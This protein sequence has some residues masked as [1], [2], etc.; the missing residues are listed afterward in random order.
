MAVAYQAIGT[1]AW[2]TGG[3]FS[4][5]WPTHQAGDIGIMILQTDTGMST[6]V[7]GWTDLVDNDNSANCKIRMLWKRASSSS[8][9]SEFV[10]HPGA[11]GGGFILTVRGGLAIGW[12][13]D[14]PIANQTGD[15]GTASN[16]VST[17]NIA[18]SATNDGV[19][20]ANAIG[21]VAVGRSYN[22]SAAQFSSWANQYSYT[23]TERYDAGNN[24]AAGGIGVATFIDTNGGYTGSVTA[25]LANACDWVSGT[26]LIYNDKPPSTGNFFLL[27]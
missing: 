4:L 18:I 7:F 16:Y 5:S 26:V 9:S 1:A 14:N 21:I 10:S 19:S 8:E 2:S 3:S 23:I 17:T 15:A 22:S 6:T 25:T 13:S 27:F 20:D 11:Y 12:N 24:S